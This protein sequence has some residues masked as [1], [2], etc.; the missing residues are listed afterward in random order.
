MDAL[1]V[2]IGKVAI[3]PSKRVQ[4]QVDKEIAL[5]LW[6]MVPVQQEKKPSLQPCMKVTEKFLLLLDKEDS[7]SLQDADC[8]MEISVAAVLG[9]VSI[10]AD[11][12]GEHCLTQAPF[13][14]PQPIPVTVNRPS[15]VAVPAPYP[16]T[17]P[18]ALP[19][20]PCHN[21]SPSLSPSTELSLC[22]YL[23]QSLSLYL[24]LGP[25]LRL[26]RYRNTSQSLSAYLIRYSPWCHS[27]A[28]P[29]EN[30]GQAATGWNTYI[31]D[32]TAL[33]TPE[34]YEKH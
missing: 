16:V 6:V 26:Y 15:H 18:S 30:S 21:R 33:I 8:V 9:M 2:V 27:L 10:P 22:P 20:C 23:K 28:R 17:A 13:F 14:L 3:V 1:T 25:F 7:I 34:S 11:G 31:K 12:V 4:K 32:P 24:K 29:F 5:A 19:L